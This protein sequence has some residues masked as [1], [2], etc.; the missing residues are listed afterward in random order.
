M[1]FRIIYDGIEQDSIYN[2]RTHQ[3]P[4]RRNNSGRT[5][6][7]RAWDYGPSPW[8][9]YA[10]PHSALPPPPPAYIEPIFQRPLAYQENRG[11]AVHREAR[12]SVR[13]ARARHVAGTGSDMGARHRPPRSGT[14]RDGP[15]SVHSLVFGTPAGR[16]LS[17]LFYSFER[18]SHECPSVLQFSDPVRGGTT[19]ARGERLLSLLHVAASHRGEGAVLPADTTGGCG[20]PTPQHPIPTPGLEPAHAVPTRRDDERYGNHDQGQPVNALPAPH[21]CGK[22]HAV[23]DPCPTRESEVKYR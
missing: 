15:E 5:A 4:A 2:R 12:H 21:L 18:L 7:A 8:H 23:G 3:P 22:V 20:D 9:Q 1:T 17:E 11:H 16:F 19:G 10:Y 6:R 13:S 14:D